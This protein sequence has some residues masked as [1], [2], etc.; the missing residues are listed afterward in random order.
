MQSGQW[1]VYL[2]CLKI[3][4]LLQRAPQPTEEL[5]VLYE[6]VE[7]S[8]AK[9]RLENDLER[10]RT[11]LGVNIGYDFSSRLYHIYDF[12][13]FSFFDLPDAAIEALIFLLNTFEPGTPHY[14]NVQVLIEAIRALLPSDQ[15]KRLNKPAVLSLNIQQIDEDQISTKVWNKLETAYLEYRL[16]E[17]DYLSPQQADSK[18]RTHIVEARKLYFDTA[19]RHYYLYGF[20]RYSL[21]P[22][23]RID[24]RTYIRYRLGRIVENS[25]NVL[26]E[27][28]PLHPPQPK[29]YE[30]RYQLAP[31]I[32]RMGVSRHF[33]NMQE[34]RQEDGSIVITAQTDDLFYATQTLL[35]YGAGCRVLGGNDLLR[36]F[37]KTILTMALIYQ[38]LE[39]Q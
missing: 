5:L 22:Y 21:G 30:V 3:L 14:H 35:H 32:A 36:D 10:L 27:R 6:N 2:R 8:A 24:H 26:P 13:D 15:K 17:F 20:C 38:E 37:Q 7:A 1:E 11:Q 25:I 23:G 29:T 9:K 12:G 16:V 33:G 18:P 39:N 28:F 34:S 19:R 4:L 31:Y